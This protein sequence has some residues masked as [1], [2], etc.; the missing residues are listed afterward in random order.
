MTKEQIEEVA[1]KFV[2][3]EGW[4]FDQVLTV[5]A[6]QQVNA[7]FEEAALIVGYEKW[8]NQTTYAEK[9]RALKIKD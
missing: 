9:I 2:F 3:P 8:S 7:A 6:I 5:F 4:T 1:H